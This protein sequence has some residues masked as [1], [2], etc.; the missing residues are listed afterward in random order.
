VYAL[1]VAYAKPI[2]FALLP[3]LAYVNA[4]YTDE[5][6]STVR[7]KTAVLDNDSTEFTV[8]NEILDGVVVVKVKLAGA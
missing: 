1:E 8:G 3:S 2:L 4:K 5:Y 7:A 6:A